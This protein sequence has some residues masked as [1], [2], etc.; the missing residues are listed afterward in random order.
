MWSH[1]NVSSELQPKSATLQ[2]DVGILSE[3]AEQAVSHHIHRHLYSRRLRGLRF[4]CT[5]PARCRNCLS[6][7]DGAT[8]VAYMSPLCAISC[9]LLSCLCQ[10][11]ELHMLISTST[12]HTWGMPNGRPNVV[13]V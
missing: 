13:A 12:L 3:F 8:R 11:Y 1:G 7:D 4:T 10:V 9:E 5:L 6:N 2:D